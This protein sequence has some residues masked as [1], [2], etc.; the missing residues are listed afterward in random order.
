M[1]VI[2]VILIIAVGYAFRD[3]F[4][5]RDN[6]PLLCLE[7]DGTITSRDG[8]GIHA[9]I[10]E[11]MKLRP[12]GPLDY[13]PFP[14]VPYGDGDYYAFGARLFHNDRQRIVNGDWRMVP[15]SVLAVRSRKIRDWRMLE[16]NLK[17]VDRLE[18]RQAVMAAIQ[19]GAVT[20]KVAA[21]FREVAVRSDNYNAVA[22]GIA[23]GCLAARQ[24]DIEELLPLGRHSELTADIVVAVME[25]SKRFPQLH[26]HLVDL[27][28]HLYDWGL[29]HVVLT[30]INHPDQLPSDRFRREL[31]VQ[32]MKNGGAL[33]GDIARILF[34]AE[35]LRYSTEALSVDNELRG[36]V[37]Q[38]IE[39]LT[40]NMESP[41][42][43]PLDGSGMEM[44]D[45]LL[46]IVRPWPDDFWKLMALRGLG[47][48][49]GLAH[50]AWPDAP[51][52]LEE[53]HELVTPLCTLDLMESALG[54]PETRTTALIVAAEVEMHALAPRILDLV[55]ET[56]DPLAAEVLTIVG[57]REHLIRLERMLPEIV[58]PARSIGTTG[59]GA[60]ERE[61]QIYAGIVAA[62]GCL[63]TNSARAIIRAAARD[64]HPM[65]R[66][67]AMVAMSRLQRW[68]LDPES[69][70]LIR[71]L[72]DDPFEGVRDRAR[73]AAA[74]H[75]MHASLDGTPHKGTLTF[76]LP[77]N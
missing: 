1:S 39:A 8:V 47:L 24:S 12:D 4:R 44:V 72:L 26:H 63:G 19:P 28:P 37:A 31:I 20:P 18:H 36:A 34:L 45:D 77:R 43:A 71:E 48:V 60:R 58:N 17:E 69:R 46:E 76:E 55:R 61:S 29:L 42:Q 23:L 11:Q 56:R 41:G 32:G 73:E 21:L 66:G 57:E 33:K 13:T 2:F 64:F 52:R 7:E 59:N 3:Y 49:F 25:Q 65:V 15:Q 40:S 27:L 35:W 10:R 75:T 14:R 22:W 70:Y 74:F 16:A 68:T 30:A 9:R 62:L 50:E 53:V 67:A 6:F 54:N 38:L 51:D 5:R